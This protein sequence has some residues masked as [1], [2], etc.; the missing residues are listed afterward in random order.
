M[1]LIWRLPLG[2]VAVFGAVLVF[3][4]PVGELVFGAG[5]GDGEGA[6]EGDG[7]GR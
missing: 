7:G 2:L 6:G 4:E 5:L 3:D 1:L